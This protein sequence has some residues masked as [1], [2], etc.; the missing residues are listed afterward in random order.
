MRRKPF[1]LCSAVSLLLCVTV[2][3]LW[4]RSQ[5]LTKADEFPFLLPRGE[6]RYT[7]RSAAGRLTLLGAPSSPP[8]PAVATVAQLVAEIDNTQLEWE[9]GRREDGTY[10]TNSPKEPREGAQAMARL[11]RG[12]S[13]RSRYSTF[14][15]GFHRTFSPRAEFSAADM[16][17]SLVRALEDP[18]RFAAAHYLLAEIARPR[19]ASSDPV[20]RTRQLTQVS[21][22]VLTY[23]Y[24]GLNVTLRFDGPEEWPGSG[25]DLAAVQRCVA[26]IDPTQVPQIRAQW[27]R[28]LDTPVISYSHFKV[29]ATT[30]I[31]P[32]LWFGARWRQMCARRQLRRRGFCP[33]CGYDLRATPGRCPE[34]G[35]VPAN[36]AAA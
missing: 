27:H 30:A 21:A 2:S 16:I 32:L 36:P 4:V 17:P 35:A 25:T 31:L 6:T 34:C 7:L 15:S 10:R 33:A 23:N 13:T 29:A 12:H 22:D 14:L 20:W 5:A 18:K 28:H 24:L 1:T 11:A 8:S 26:V 9:A 19:G 3:V